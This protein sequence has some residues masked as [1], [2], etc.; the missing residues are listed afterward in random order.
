VVWRHAGQGRPEVEFVVA[1]SLRDTAA[2]LDE[3]RPRGPRR[4]EPSRF[5]LSV[6]HAPRRLHVGFCLRSPAGSQVEPHCS[7]AVERVVAEMERL[8]HIVTEDA[9]TALFE[10]GER[11]LFGAV[12]G[13]LG[14]REC[15]E[16]LEE[17]LGRPVESCDVEPFLWDLAA[18]RVVDGEGPAPEDVQRA[19][20]WTRSWAQV[21]LGWFDQRDILVTPTVAELAPRLD[22][23]DPGE[24]APLELLEKMVPHMAFTEPWN[25]TGQP[26]ISLPLGWSP[27]GLPV[28]VQLVGR[29]DAE[30][31]LLAAAAQLLDALGEPERRPRVHA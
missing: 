22:S 21:L 5:K 15:L 14:Y 7:A 31:D 9:P 18:G 6:T 10:Y 26:A 17:R 28:G 16:E 3:L 13:P 4:A 12:L 11:A 30:D 29:A 20:E 23:L 8:G 25:V 2:L 27:E 24:L 1:R 19:I